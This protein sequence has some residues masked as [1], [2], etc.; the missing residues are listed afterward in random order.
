M[1]VSAPLQGLGPNRTVQTQAVGVGFA[2]SPLW[3]WESK[4][5]FRN[6]SVKVG[7]YLT[8]AEESLPQFVHIGAKGPGYW[9][10]DSPKSYKS[11]YLRAGA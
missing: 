2:R 9:M 1:S 8:Y 10:W 3:G 11:N 7:H 4:P 6:H 5:L